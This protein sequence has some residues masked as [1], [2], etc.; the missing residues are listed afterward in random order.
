M[1][2]EKTYGQFAQDLWVTYGV[3]PSKRDGFYVDVGSADGERLSNTKL[4]DDHG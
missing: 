2:L 3:A 4:L 1:G